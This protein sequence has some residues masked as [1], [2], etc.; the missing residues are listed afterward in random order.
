MNIQERVKNLKPEHPGDARMI[1]LVQDVFRDI[2]IKGNATVANATTQEILSW[3]KLRNEKELVEAI[4]NLIEQ[5]QIIA[6][7]VGPKLQPQTQTVTKPK[8]IATMTI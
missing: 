5:K 3:L 6:S 1:A 2:E 7:E 8:A 4:E